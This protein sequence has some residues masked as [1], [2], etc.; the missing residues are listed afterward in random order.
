MSKKIKPEELQDLT[1]EQLSEVVEGAIVEIL[2][3]ELTVLETPEVKVHK[4]DPI[5]AKIF[6]FKARG[7]NH[8]AIGAMMGIDSELV[9]QILDGG[10]GA[11]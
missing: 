10:K 1:T 5:R 9:K 2:G 4:E 11:N 6:E 7:H 8:N 3:E